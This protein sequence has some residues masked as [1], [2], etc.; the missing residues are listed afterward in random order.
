MD[1][2]ED[3]WLLQTT[4]YNT[5]FYTHTMTLCFLVIFGGLRSLTIEHVGRI[6][7]TQ[8]PDVVRK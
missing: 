7:L 2:F 8:C 1:N 3:Y 6:P 5:T 4:P